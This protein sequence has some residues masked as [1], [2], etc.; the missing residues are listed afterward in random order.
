MPPYCSLFLLPT[1]TCRELYECARLAGLTYRAVY[2]VRRGGDV[3]EDGGPGEAAGRAAAQDPLQSP[4]PA[5]VAHQ[6]GAEVGLQY[7]ILVVNLAKPPSQPHQ[8]V[9]RCTIYSMN[10]QKQIHQ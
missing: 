9:R 10:S 3:C 1:E 8:L 7:L 6:G 2:P 4:H 5:R